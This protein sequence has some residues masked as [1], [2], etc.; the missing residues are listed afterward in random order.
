MTAVGLLCRFLMGQ[1]PQH[2]PVMTQHADLLLKALPEWDPEGFATDM[3]YWY[4]GSHAMVRM[5]GRYS[6][7]WHKALSDAVLPAQRTD[8]A[9]R[10]SWDPVGPWGYSGGRVY[11]TSLMV[12]A[13]E[14]GDR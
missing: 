8:G 2:E 10:G 3:C 14:S 9:H 1:D 12:L 4:Y 7:A 13:L 6:R 5:G 11:S